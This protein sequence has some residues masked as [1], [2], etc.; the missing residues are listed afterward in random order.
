VTEAAYGLLLS[1]VLLIVPEM[2]PVEEL[3][4]NPL[5]RLLAL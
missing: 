5:G 4:L 2:S 1:A 3:M